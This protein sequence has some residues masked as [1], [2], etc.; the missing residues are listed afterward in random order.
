MWIKKIV[1]I[2]QK[3][4]ISF[5]VSSLFWKLFLIFQLSHQTKMKYSH[6]SYKHLTDVLEGLLK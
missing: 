1:L 2:R 4:Y 6:S 5:W 3:E